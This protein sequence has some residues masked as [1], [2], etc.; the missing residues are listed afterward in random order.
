M[1]K[2]VIPNG[3]EGEEAVYREQVI[4][5]YGENPFIEALP[6]I[7]A[8]EEVV[9]KLAVYPYYSEE[10]RNLDAHYRIHLTQKLFQCFQPLPQHLDLESRISRVIRQGYLPRN[11][12]SKEYVISLK[13]GY[14]AVQNCDI[15]ANQH[16]RSTARG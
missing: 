13:D 1:A 10:E 5:E 8:P 6:P 4:R 3:A 14:R 9:E 16:F 11:P 15:N 2:V 12:I 7:C